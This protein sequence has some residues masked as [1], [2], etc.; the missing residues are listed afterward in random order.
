MLHGKSAVLDVV[1]PQ[2][3][4]GYGQ[5]MLVEVVVGVDPMLVIDLW[6]LV[7]GQIETSS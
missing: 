1:W 2:N 5:H 6:P 3:R 7:I 4:M